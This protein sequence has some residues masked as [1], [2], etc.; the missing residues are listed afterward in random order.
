MLPPYPV[1]SYQL[2]GNKKTG[3]RKP[4]LQEMFSISG[5]PAILIFCKIRGFPSHPHEWFGFFQ[6]IQVV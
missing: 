1:F 4:V 6:W 2:S 5:N 3:L